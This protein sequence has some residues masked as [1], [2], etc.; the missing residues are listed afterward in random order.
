MWGVCHTTKKS[1]HP[2]KFEWFENKRQVYNISKLWYKDTIV[3]FLLC[4]IWLWH[5]LDC[6]SLHCIWVTSSVYYHSESSVNS[7]DLMLYFQWRG[8]WS[9]AES[10]LLQYVI[11]CWCRNTVN[12]FNSQLAHPAMFILH[13]YLMLH[14]IK[15]WITLA[16]DIKLK[17]FEQCVKTQLSCNP[18]FH[19]QIVTYASLCFSVSCFNSPPC[20]YLVL[21]KQAF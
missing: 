18:S 2:A 8:L 6:L 21:V 9:H 20:M 3:L 19:R 1:N 10:V 14:C 5:K 11:W 7:C 17:W 15:D 16:P 13:W 4:A 12:S